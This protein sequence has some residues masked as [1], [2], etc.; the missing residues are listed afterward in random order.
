MVEDA[1]EGGGGRGRVLGGLGNSSK[2]ESGGRPEVPGELCF[3]ILKG[4][5]LKNLKK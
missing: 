1:V 4:R 2:C 3:F 5:S